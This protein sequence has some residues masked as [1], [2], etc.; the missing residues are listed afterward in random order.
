M[1]LVIGNKVLMYK[2]NKNRAIDCSN[3]YITV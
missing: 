3:I 2:Q 1:L